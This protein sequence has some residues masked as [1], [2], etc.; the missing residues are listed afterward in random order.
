MKVR[1]KRNL[2]SWDFYRKGPRYTEI[3]SSVFWPVGSIGFIVGR[4]TNYYGKFVIVKDENDKRWYIREEDI[5]YIGETE[6]D[7]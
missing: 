5:E 7:T 3:S 1:A 4:T 6:N 2:R